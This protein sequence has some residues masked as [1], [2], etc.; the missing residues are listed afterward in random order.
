MVK[1]TF[2]KRKIYNCNANIYFNQKHLRK[3]NLISNCTI[4]KIPNNS[5]ASKFTQKK[6]TKEREKHDKTTS[7][8]IRE[9]GIHY[10][11]NI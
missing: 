5:Q 4:A 9:V 10:F 1:F 2:L 3:K 11:C 6:Y 8:K 7:N